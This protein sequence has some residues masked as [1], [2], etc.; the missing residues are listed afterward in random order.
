MRIK[1]L[2]DSD[3]FSGGSCRRGGGGWRGGRGLVGLACGLVVAALLASG[4]GGSGASKGGTT[5]ALTGVASV[6]HVSDPGEVVVRVGG[7]AITKEVFAH[8]LAGLEKFEGL[9]AAVAPVPPG[10]TA[11]IAHLEA[12]SSGSASSRGALR[13][14]CEKQYRQLVQEALDPLISRWWVVGGAAEAGVSVS[15]AEVRR[16]VARDEAGAGRARLLA[17]LADAGETLAEL[18]VET[19]VKLLAEKIRHKLAA[20]T[21]KVTAARVLAYYD[22]HRSEFATPQRRRLYIARTA[23][24][25]EALKVKSEILAGRSFASVVK[26]LS[27]AQP[28]YSKDGLVPGYESHM[29]RQA[30]LNEAILKARL[31]TVEGPVRITLGYYVFE[32]TRVTP[33]VQ[34]PFAKARASI[35]AKLPTQLYDERLSAFVK[36]WRARWRA[37]TRCEPG[38]VVA[39]CAGGPTAAEDPYTLD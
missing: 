33:A 28:I 26:G 24:S 25:R 3:V 36:G 8:A 39:K 34:E 1:V 37:R 21:G 11:C 35:E 16:Q 19:R 13:G 2:L 9:T 23:T 4:C 31:G 27:L 6:A 5:G 10:Y 29:Y 12:T 15:D 17:N 18:A 20:E 30:P 14:E 32:V 22:A 7:H 38:Y